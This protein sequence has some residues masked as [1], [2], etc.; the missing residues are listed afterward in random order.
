MLRNASVALGEGSW[1][2]IS[3]CVTLSNAS[4]FAFGLL[5]K[6]TGEK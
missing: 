6:N 4:C 1:I 3:V 2:E 5:L